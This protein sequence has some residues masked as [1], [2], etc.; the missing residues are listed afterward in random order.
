MTKVLV[1]ILAVAVVVF[2]ASEGPVA[3]DRVY[4]SERLTFDG[5]ADPDFHGQVVNIHP[6]GPVHGALER[7]QVIRAGASTTYEVW[8]QF[9]ADGG[10]VDFMS[11]AELKTNRQGNGHASA[12]FSAADLAPFSGATVHIRWV[13]KVGGTVRYSTPCTTVTID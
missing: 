9:C 3:A 1:R 12:G 4:H 6:N 2:L 10:F 13:L 5:G 8:I 7:Y 11:T